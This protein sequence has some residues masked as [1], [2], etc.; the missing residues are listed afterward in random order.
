MPHRVP[1]PEL[2]HVHRRLRALLRSSPRPTPSPPHATPRPPLLHPLLEPEVGRPVQPTP[3]QRL[4]L[5]LSLNQ[6]HRTP[7]SFPL[8]VRP[9][10]PSRTAEPPP[11]KTRTSPQG[12]RQHPSAHAPPPTG[13]TPAAPDRPVLQPSHPCP[14]SPDPSAAAAPADPS[15]RPRPRPAQILPPELQRLLRDSRSLP[16][17]PGR[18][19]SR[20]SQ[21]PPPA[22]RLTTFAPSAVVST[23]TIPTRTSTSL[24]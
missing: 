17:P 18:P 12:R 3:L 6:N 21:T 15:T 9:P 5:L 11:P 24:P 7:I 10:S 14:P 1:A 20:R 22:V 16:H 2:P 19:S 4:L 8:Q 23:D 13:P